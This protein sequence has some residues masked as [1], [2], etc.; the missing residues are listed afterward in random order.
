MYE[1]SQL[2]SGRPSWASVM[3]NMLLTLTGSENGGFTTSHILINNTLFLSKP[4]TL[5]VQ[6]QN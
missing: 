2:Q 4:L 6:L 1:N 3:T 5:N